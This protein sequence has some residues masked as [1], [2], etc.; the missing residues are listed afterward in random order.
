MACG[1]FCV[2]M[3]SK[4]N[5][6][7]IL[8]YALA[9]IS[10][11]RW[12]SILESLSW[13]CSISSP[14]MTVRFQTQIR[15]NIRTRRSGESSPWPHPCQYELMIRFECRHPIGF[16]CQ[17][18]PRNDKTEQLLGMVA[19]SEPTDWAKGTRERRDRLPN[20]NS[21]TN[22]YVYFLPN[23]MTKTW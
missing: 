6:S 2:P 22:I 10:P 23:H 3:D 17:F 18:T 13:R 4:E 19:L 12:R 14:W 21:E 5:L 16:E 8:E 9:C 1:K 20:S 15:S 7:V 11:I